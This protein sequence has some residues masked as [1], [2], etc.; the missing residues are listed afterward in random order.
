M[1]SA[2][3]QSTTNYNLVAG[4]REQLSAA[5]IEKIAQAPPGSVSVVETL[6]DFNAAISK[7]FGELFPGGFFLGSEPT[8]AWR[9]NGP[10]V[11]AHITQNLL[12]SLLFNI[13]ILSNYEVLDIPFKADLGHYLLFII[14]FGLSMAIYPAFLVLYPT[15]ERLRGIRSMHYSNGVRPLPLW[16]AYL[17]FDFTFIIAISF[18]SIIIF[19]AT[20]DVWYAIGYLLPILLLYGIA[21]GLYSYV[22]S[23]FSASQLAAFAITAAI[24]TVFFLAYFVILMVVYTLNESTHQ[25]STMNIAFFTMGLL[26]PIVS[27]ARALYITLNVFGVSCR[28]KQLAS[29][30]GAIDLFGGPLLYLTLQSFALFGIV[31]Y[32]ESTSSLN[33]RTWSRKARADDIELEDAQIQHTGEA[34]VNDGLRVLSLRKQFKKH[35]AVDDVT[36]SIPES[37]CFALVGPNGAGKSTSISMIRGDVQP[38]GNQSEIYING[39]SALRHRSKA[40]ANL[41]VCPQID[42]LDHMTVYEHLHFYAQIRGLKNVT[43]SVEEIIEAAGLSDFTTRIASKLSGGNKRKLSLAIA[44]VG[45][46]SV[47]LLDEPSSGMDAVSKRIM[48]RTLASL[49]PGR[50]LL[51]TTHSMEEA[52]ALATRVGIISG[53]MLALGTISEMKAR[54]GKAYFVQLMHRSKARTSKSEMERIQW[55]VLEEFP[56]ARFNAWSGYGQLK[57]EIPVRDASGLMRK[58]SDVFRQLEVAKEALGV[59]Y[60]SV[61]SATLGRIFLEVV[62]RHQGGEQ[63]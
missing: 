36:F 18:I 61:S 19:G 41:G 37:E 8:I 43:Q 6:E 21:A 17:L 25:T 54:Y 58:I 16:A 34:R 31:L 11:M 12:N 52:D 35:V 9:A 38:S 59:E 27:L 30:A 56:E 46:P 53:R 42:P 62:G 60:Y 15:M 7:R 2:T 10:P 5:A 51:L 40:R 22:I 20:S 44:I 13:T 39:L 49:T 26:S 63:E 23:L 55:W 47:L 14:Y 32:K 4:P 24:H 57:V 33:L 3:D 1:F 28:S 29:Y 48:W 50:S 45:N